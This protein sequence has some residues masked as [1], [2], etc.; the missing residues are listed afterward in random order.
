M[1]DGDRLI[2]FLRSVSYCNLVSVPYIRDGIYWL[3]KIEEWKN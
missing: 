1:K 2:A 3:E